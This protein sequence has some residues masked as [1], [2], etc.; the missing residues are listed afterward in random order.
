MKKKA[1]QCKKFFSSIC[2]VDRFL[3][4][5]MLLLFA[6][7]IF[8]LLSG[9]RVSNDHNS[10]NIIV[11]TSSASI[12]G[13]F[14]SGSSGKSAISAQATGRQAPTSPRTTDPAS[15][16]TF[17]QQQGQIGF[18]VSNEGTAEITGGVAVANDNASNTQPCCSRVQIYIVSTI[19]LISFLVLM[20]ARNNSE[21][22]SELTATIS[23]LRDFIAGCI[24]FLISCGRI[25][26]V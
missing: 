24:G 25:R 14:V 15:P 2:L 1:L 18:Q 3:I 12:F 19:C 4:L 11:R 13:Y 16:E 21:T 17:P 10:I 22:T 20:I 6:Y 7:M 8:H 5:F 23:Q 9:A 26:V